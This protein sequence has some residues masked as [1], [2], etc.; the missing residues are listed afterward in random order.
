MI[1]LTLD[2]DGDGEEGMVEEILPEQTPIPRSPTAELEHHRG[3][4]AA[5]EE[6]EAKKLAL[7]EFG[8]ERQRQPTPS[9][10]RL[11]P[12]ARRFKQE[13]V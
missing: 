5:R 13:P 3:P 9:L 4:S 10:F 8:R 1:D 12:T 6:F 11:T 2:D 7:A